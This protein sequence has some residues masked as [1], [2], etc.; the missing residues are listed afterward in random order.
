MST[1]A[2]DDLEVPELSPEWFERA[3]KPNRGAL[4]RG[5]KRAVFIEEDIARRFGSDE[6]LEGALR[7]LLAASAHVRRAI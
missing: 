2:E 6:E 4:R 5:T 7:D 3:W 1:V